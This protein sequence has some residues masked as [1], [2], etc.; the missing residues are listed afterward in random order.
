MGMI[1]IGLPGIFLGLCVPGASSEITILSGGAIKPGL[2][3]AVEAF[4]KQSGKKVEVTF[5]TAPRI[6]RRLFAGD[7]F[8]VVIAP[9]ALIAELQEAGIADAEG[10]D[11]G[12]VGSG[13]AVRPCGP[14]PAIASAEDIKKAVLEAESIVFNQAS[15]GIYIENLFKEMGVWERVKPKTSRYAT[16]AEVMQHLLKGDGREIGFGPITEIMLEQG[17]GLVYVGPLPPEIQNYTSYAAVSLT[18]CSH[19]DEARSLI[20]FL[21]GPVGKSLFEA[22]GI[23]RTDS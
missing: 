16:G 15:T 5:N 7:S 10:S 6:R 9:L 17:N 14:I 2:K 1:S 19:K 8:D 21:C 22:A 13:V 20:G 4:A 3:A 12:R 18:S 23:S 11:L